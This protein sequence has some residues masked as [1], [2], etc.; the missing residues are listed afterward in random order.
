MSENNKIVPLAE[1]GIGGYDFSGDFVRS[2]FLPQLQWPQAGQIY[3]EMSKNDP[4]IGAI[5]FM[6]K[7]LVR[8][9]RWSV[10]P[11]GDT[12]QD[13]EAAEFLTSCMNDMDQSWN[14]F[15]AD[16]LSMMTY[17]WSFHEVVYKVRGGDSKDVR[18]KS[19][20]CDGK[21]GWRKLASRS[22]RTCYGWEICQETGKIIALKQQAAPDYR[23]RI[24][25][26]EKA[27]H[28]KV[29]DNYGDPYG[30]SMLRNTYR[31]WFF[32]KRIEEIEGIGI[33]RD[34][35]GLPVLIPPANVDIWDA[36]DQRMVALKRNAENLVKSIRRDQSEGVVIPNGWE[37]KLLSTGS[38]RQ[39]DTNQIL[40]RY[41][42]RIA[43]TFLA[44]IVMLGA[45]KVGSFALADV[46][47][48]LLSAALET[49]LDSI[50]DGINRQE[51]PRLMKLN[52]YQLENLPQL[53][54]DD[55]ETPDIEQLAT[56]LKSMNEV[57][58]DTRD[59]AIEEFVRRIA[60]LPATAEEVKE[61]KQQIYQ[62]WL[63]AKATPMD[64]QAQP[65]VEEN[66]SQESPTEKPT[67]EGTE[68]MQKAIDETYTLRK[69]CAR[70]PKGEQAICENCSVYKT[71]VILKAKRGM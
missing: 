45:D 44:D 17:G 37:L 69:L 63:N 25:P 14:E 50:A 31:P 58:M 39:F 4:T 52:G 59:P 2:D 36:Q 40:N 65:T 19:L 38:Q 18:C 23:M 13:R 46:K 49:L 67:E 24:I 62:V 11:G 16:A 8:R 55:V 3:E 22:Q 12:P 34:L 15:V 54:P 33:E 20:H 29:E 10:K 47:K 42:Q 71:C 30:K 53:I 21:I 61:I 56:L 7:Q 9:C 5:L 28:L 66:P 70:N 60:S 26:V 64:M 68:D 48:S 57:G 32:K 35:A 27:I 1:Y 6:A 43:I 51:V 41:D